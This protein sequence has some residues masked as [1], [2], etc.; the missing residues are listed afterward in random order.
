MHKINT[1]TEGDKNAEALYD[2]MQA[3]ISATN[4][5]ATDKVMADAMA[6]AL[7]DSHRTLQQNFFR[8]FVRAMDTYGETNFY[9]A[10]NNAS[11]DFAKDISEKDYH[12]PFI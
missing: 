6:Q 7:L 11:V 2:A 9:D 1:M 10:R 12:F 5:M 8:L 4:P 3:V